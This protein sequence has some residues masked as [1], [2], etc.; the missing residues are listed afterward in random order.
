MA[1]GTVGVAVNVGGTIGVSV[2]TGVDVAAGV[3]PPQALKTIAIRTKRMMNLGCTGLL[4]KRNVRIIHVDVYRPKRL[5]GLTTL[6]V[7]PSGFC[8]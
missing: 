7:K 3:P 4:Q 2:G 8:L 6:Q 1:S 5:S